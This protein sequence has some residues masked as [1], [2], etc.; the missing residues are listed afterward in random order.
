MRRLDIWRDNES[1]VCNRCA[2][3]AID[4]VY[5][6]EVMVHLRLTTE[7]ATTLKE[8]LESYAADLRMEI[9]DTDAPRSGSR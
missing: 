5:R 8:A 3:V 2:A 1:K 6:R 7:E 4:A 9:A